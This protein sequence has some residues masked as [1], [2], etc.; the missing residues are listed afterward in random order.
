M[1]HRFLSLLLLFFIGARLDAQVIPP[2][3]LTMQEAV[4]LALKNNPELESSRLDVEKARA[5]VREAWGYTMPSIGLSGQ[6]TRAIKKSIFYLPGIFF[7]QPADVSVPVEIGSTHSIAFGF[8]ATQVIFNGAVFIGVGA[9]QVYSEAAAELYAGKRTEVIARARKSYYGV[10]IAREALNLVRQSLANAEENLKNVRLLRAQELL[11]E[12]DELR[13]TVGVENIRPAVIQSETNY[14]L[15][16]DAL[17]NTIGIAS[18]EPI[19]VEGDLTFELYN[20]GLLSSA[21]SVLVESNSNLRA[22]RLQREVNQA[23]VKAERSNYLPTLVAFGNYQYQTQK[24]SFRISMTDFIGSSA[25][26]L[27]L[28]FNI[29]QGMQTNA[30]VDQAAIEVLKSESQLITVENNLR[31]ALHAS[32]GTLEQSR[33][34]LTAQEKNVETAERGYKIVTARFLA[35]AATQLEVNDA[36]LALTQAKVNRIQAIYDYLV[37]SAD[38]DLLLGRTPDFLKESNE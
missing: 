33:K 11:S 18:S 22:L 20:P 27:Q 29:F 36:Q 3:L 15:A 32:L 14:D 28:S 10:L 12:Y 31:T 30:R 8:T 16:L 21:E 13:A 23:F 37:A 35:N 26:G 4:R 25:V 34:R 38:L 7:D 5:R 1:L 9:T 2:H 24:N 6:Y 19:T 17:R